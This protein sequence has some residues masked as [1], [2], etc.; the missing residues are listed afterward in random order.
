M[1]SRGYILH[2]VWGYDGTLPTRTVETHIWR[3][4]HKLGDSAEAP[5]WLVTAP[6]GYR[7]QPDPIAA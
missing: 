2:E 6:G 4:R 7:L 5:R 1:L 3:L